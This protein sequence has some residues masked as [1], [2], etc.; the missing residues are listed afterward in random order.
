ML[1]DEAHNVAVR[2]SKRESGQTRRPARPPLGHDHQ[3]NYVGMGT[4]VLAMKPHLIVYPLAER[5]NRQTA[6]N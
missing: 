5:V 1:I 6:R 3:S 2:G 4:T